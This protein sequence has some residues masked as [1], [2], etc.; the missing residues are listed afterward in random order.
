[1][2]GVDGLV[3]AHQLLSALIIIPCTVQQAASIIVYLESW[4]CPVKK[5]CIA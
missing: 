3:E 2:V 5:A 4:A 1:M